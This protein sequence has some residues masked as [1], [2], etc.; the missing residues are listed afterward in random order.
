MFEVVERD[1]KKVVSA[2]YPAVERLIDTEDFTEINEAFGKAYEELEEI[3]RK[4]RG[5]KKGRDAKKAARAIENVMALFKEL[6]EI[7]Y[8]IQ[9]MVGEASSKGRKRQ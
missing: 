6:L 9:E 3:A 2:G 1:G 7:K 4:K 5:L 8:K